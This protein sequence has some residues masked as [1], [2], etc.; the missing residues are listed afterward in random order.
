MT[1]NFDSTTNTHGPDIN[2]PLLITACFVLAVE[3]V[4]VIW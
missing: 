4:E 1:Q 2:V 3:V